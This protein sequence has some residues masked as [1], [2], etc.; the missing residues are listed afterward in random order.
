L[1]ERLP[2]TGMLKY[3]QP[4]RSGSLTHHEKPAIGSGLGKL[5]KGLAVA[6]AVIAGVSGAPRPAAADAAPVA[7][8][9]M[10]GTQAVSVIRSPMRFSKRRPI[11]T[12]WCDRISI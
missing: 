8:I 11:S 2:P 6:L 7:F 4:P 9:R 1:I 3:P 12:S 10:L 5:A